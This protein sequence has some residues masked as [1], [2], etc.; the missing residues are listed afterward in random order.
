MSHL[1]GDD[2]RKRQAI[3]QISPITIGLSGTQVW[4]L[5]HADGRSCYLK[6]ATQPI[7]RQELRAERDA[8]AWLCKIGARMSA[9]VPEPLA[10]TTDDASDGYDALLLTEIPGL[11]ACDP[12]FAADVPALARR[13][14]EGLRLIHAVE[15][16]GCPLDQ[17]LDAKLAEAQRRVEAGLVNVDDFDEERQ[18]RSASDLFCEALATRPTSEELVFTHG[19]YCLPNVFLSQADPK[20]AR[21]TGFVDWGGAGVADRYQDLALA[22]R[23]LEYNFGRG[24]GEYFWAGYGVGEVD[25]TKVAYY[26][27]L[28]EFF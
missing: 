13:L 11:M 16:A 2:W 1:L 17:R 22:T 5:D 28:D 21:I 8:L 14:G 4:R 27:L 6:L 3:S 19:D 24:W 15:I 12:V 25:R 7:Q 26:R 20:A 23:S 18:G 9:L 10:Y